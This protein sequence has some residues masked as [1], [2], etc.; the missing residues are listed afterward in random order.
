MSAAT[1]RDEDAV[2]ALADFGRFP[3]WMWRNAD[4]L[5]FIGWLRAHNDAQPAASASASTGSICTASQLDAK[6]C[7]PIST[8]SIPTRPQ[9]ARDRYGCFDQ[10]GE[11]MQEYGYAASFGLHPS[12]EREVIDAALDL[13]RQRAEY[14]SRDGRVAAD[15]F[16]FAEQNARAGQERRRVLPDDVQRAAT[17]RGT[18]ATATW[19]TRSSE[20][21]TLPRAHAAWRAR[22]SSGR[23][24]RIWATRARPRWASAAS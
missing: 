11:E 16:F 2:E 12:C 18:C 9:R 21:L 13:H 5:D 20:L 3:T 23:T 15:E 7:S 17:S 24:T 4:V 6:R 1:S 19:P 8:R 10:F 22:S 14:A